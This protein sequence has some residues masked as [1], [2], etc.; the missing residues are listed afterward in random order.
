MGR[1]DGSRSGTPVS[2]C[3][4]GECGVGGRVARE[5]RAES[6]ER[7]DRGGEEGV[8]RYGARAGSAAVNGGEGGVD[9]GDE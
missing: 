7:E 8:A 6:D 5:E 1:E 3:E 9:M 4:G 2:G